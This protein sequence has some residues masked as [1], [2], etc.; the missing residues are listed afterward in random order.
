[1]PQTCDHPYIVRLEVYFDTVN[2]LGVTQSVTDR[3]T[4]MWTD[5]QTL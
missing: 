1:M 5:G 4:D 2:R 3:A